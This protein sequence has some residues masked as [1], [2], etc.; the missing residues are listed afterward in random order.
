MT[1]NVGW[2]ERKSWW[3]NLRQPGQVE[4]EIRGHRRTGIAQALRDERGG[5]R[6]EVK[7]DPHPVACTGQ[8]LPR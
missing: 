2:S 3:R 7:L 6:V 4:L 8:P 1:V 5:V